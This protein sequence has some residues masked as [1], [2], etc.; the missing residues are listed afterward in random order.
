[1][2]LLPMQKE[3]PSDVTVVVGE[4]MAERSPVDELKNDDLHDSAQVPSVTM[5]R[6]I[7]EYMGVTDYGWSGSYNSALSRQGP[8]RGLVRSTTFT[9]PATSHPPIYY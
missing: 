6:Y 8:V 3:M 5:G 2:T 7:H 1:M 9:V 4:Q